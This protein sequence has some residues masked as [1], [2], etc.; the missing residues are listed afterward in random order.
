[1]ARL[2]E[3]RLTPGTLYRASRLDLDRAMPRDG[4][5][6]DVLEDPRHLL[7][8][9]DPEPPY[10]NEAAGD[11]LLL[12]RESYH[13]VGGFNERVRFTKIH[14]D[15][16]FCF[17]AHHHGLA[18]ESMG[19][20]YHIDHDGS[21]I[22]TRHTYQ[23]GYADA[24]FGPDWNGLQ[25]FWNR[26]DWGV[27]PAIAEQIGASTWLRTPEEAGPVLSLV[28]HGRGDASARA[29]A[30]SALLADPLAIEVLV[31][32][33]TA[34]L[35]V[36]LEAHRGDARLRLL[37]ASDVAPGTP[38][39]SA[40]RIASACAHGRHLAFVPGSVAIDRLGDIVA[41][42]RDAGAEAFVHGV[43]VDPDGGPGNRVLTIVS[44]RALD[45]LD[46]I[47]ALAA[48]PIDAF[49]RRARRAFGVTVIEGAS[50]R[51]LPSLDA[52]SHAR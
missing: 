25:P 23:A 16:Q 40:L 41:R 28:L 18:I 11:F 47:D 29:S 7:R 39:G 10:L 52:M 37:D 32:D 48:D 24:P 49:A 44:R 15:G 19:P 50:V 36:A 2:A 6:W 1:V 3:G 22:N 30:V 45:R 31:V 35:V 4:V 20:V 46:G 21:F 27:R 34:A 42:L 26:E 17:Q 14:K 13:R 43:G 5:T 9:F 33:P 8:R 51:P 38:M 12:D